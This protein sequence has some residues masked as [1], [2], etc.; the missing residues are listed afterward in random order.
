MLTNKAN[1]LNKAKYF[2]APSNADEV[3]VL[4]KELLGG[5]ERIERAERTA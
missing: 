1:E 4:K 5:L 2:L 3:Q